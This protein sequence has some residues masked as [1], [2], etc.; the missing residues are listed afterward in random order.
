MKILGF[1]VAVLLTISVVAFCL[2]SK[3]KNYGKYHIGMTRDEVLKITEN[4]WPVEYIKL[5]RAEYDADI[6]GLKEAY[7]SIHDPECKY[8][9]YFN[10]QK[11][12]DRG[13]NGVKIN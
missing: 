8:Y 1:I 13:R 3:K 10:S 4:K 6:K 12:F 2:N 11:I 5:E 7:S 9:L